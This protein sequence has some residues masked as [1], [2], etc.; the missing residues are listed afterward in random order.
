MP[1]CVGGI[2]YM[3]DRIRLDRYLAEAGIG[4]RSEWKKLI[5]A[6]RVQVVKKPAYH[7]G[8][9]PDEGTMRAAAVQGDMKIDPAE[10]EVLLD[11]RLVKRLLIPVLMLNKPA[12]VVSATQDLHDRTVLDLIREPWADELF[13]VGRLDKDT[14]GLLL[15]TSD[16]KLAHELLSPKKHVKKTYF[17]V[18]SGAPD[19]ELIGR[20]QEG[21]D[22][23]EKKNTLPAE[24]V[25]LFHKPLSISD[26][27]RFDAGSV[28]ETVSSFGSAPSNGIRLPGECL[29]KDQEDTHFLLKSVSG[30][31]LAR[32]SEDEC[33]TLVTITEG[34]YHQIK[35]MFRSVGR[36]VHFLKR[37]SMGG[38]LLDPALEPGRYRPLSRE[39]LDLLSNLRT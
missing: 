21:L 26:S 32:C 3:P 25:F 7:S 18:V 2:D 12:G 34:R 27:V 33:C 5:R 31:D 13:P 30:K 23:G 19:P 24:L 4:T 37:I 1:W 39:E 8:Q 38:L 17:A 20:F 16:G 15:L 6:G 22:I 35:R 36:E 9:E 11:R 29:M 10:D 14:E 28:I